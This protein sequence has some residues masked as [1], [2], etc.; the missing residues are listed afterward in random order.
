[1]NKKCLKEAA[2][3]WFDLCFENIKY[4]KNVKGGKIKKLKRRKQNEYF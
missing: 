2:K 1:M 3:K 4:K